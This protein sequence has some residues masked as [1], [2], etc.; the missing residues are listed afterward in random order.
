MKEDIAK[1][2]FEYLKKQGVKSSI[3]EIEN[4]IEIPPSKLGDY[5]FPCFFLSKKLRKNP[6]EIAK[7]IAEKIKKNKS[8]ERIQAVGSYV[9]FFINKEE[10]VEK[11][12]KEI[13]RR[14]DDFGKT[15]IGK[16][17]RATNI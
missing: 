6:N 13:L 4:F 15:N 10:F 5:A 17:D 12:I 2:L 1:L 8:L 14:K 3:N 16:K 7:N 9:N 11:T